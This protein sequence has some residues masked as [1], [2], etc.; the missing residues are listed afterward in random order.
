VRREKLSD[1]F[2][3]VDLTPILELV[4]TGAVLAETEEFAYP[5][6]DVSDH[7]KFIA[8]ALVS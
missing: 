2:P 3:E 4:P 7:D 1:Q 6:C 5:V 8:C